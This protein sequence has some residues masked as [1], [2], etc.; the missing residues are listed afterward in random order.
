[1]YISSLLQTVKLKHKEIE[2][3]NRDLEQLKN[4]FN[5]AD[6]IYSTYS[7]VKKL[8]IQEIQNDIQKDIDRFYSFIHK[9]EEHNDF[10]LM[11]DL[12]KKGSTEIKVNSYKN[13]IDPRAFQ[14]EGHLDSLGLCIFL[15]FAKKFNISSNLIILDDIV[16]TIDSQH[17]M[18]ICELIYENFSDKQLIIT[19]HDNVWFEQLITFQ[20]K[21]DIK[22]KFLNLK[23]DYWDINSG[24]KFSKYMSRE[25]RIKKKLESNDKNSAGNEI[26]QYL[27]YV[28]KELCENIHAEVPFKNDGKYMVDEL[29]T[30]SKRRVNKLIKDVTWKNEIL[31]IFKEIESVR[32]LTNILSHDNL[33]I[34]QISINEIG[35]LY[36]V[37][38]NLENKFKCTSCFKNLEYDRS[39]SLIRCVNKKCSKRLIIETI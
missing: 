18:K 20:N 16:T 38:K 22:N 23:I 13:Y 15:A 27:E 3:R 5:I 9:D 14:S 24:P 30:S 21:Y 6:L 7:E 1:M 2:I 34:L 32:F 37:I 11:I 25:D 33:E 12:K 17:R 4:M 28:S 35:Y 31:E 8:K 26:R 39:G 19:T 36:T 10:K 29:L